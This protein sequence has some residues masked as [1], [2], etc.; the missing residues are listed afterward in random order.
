MEM[1]VQV[2]LTPAL[3]YGIGINFAEVIV[4]FI[5]C[6]LFLANAWKG[7]IGK[8]VQGK[9]SV[10]AGLGLLAG[11]FS[12]VLF[13]AYDYVSQDMTWFLMAGVVQMAA[14]LVIFLAFYLALKPAFQERGRF[15]VIPVILFIGTFYGSYALIAGLGQNLTV[16]LAGNTMVILC[17]CLICVYFIRAIRKKGA[18][19]TRQILVLGAGWVTAVLGGLMTS[20]NFVAQYPGLELVVKGIGHTLAVGGYI[21]WI[22]GFW[23][24]PVL[25]E[26]E[27]RGQLKHLYLIMKSGICI[28]DQ[29]YA[30]DGT[31]DSNL[32]AGGIT[33]ITALIQEMTSSK[34]KLEVIHQEGVN[35]LLHPGT[36]TTGVLVAGADLQILHRK[37]SAF[38]TEGES[39]FQ[40]E[41]PSWQ[42]KLEV[43]APLRVLA[44]RHF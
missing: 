14:L 19:V 43:F 38:V 5:G 15:L 35:I 24:L 28:Y 36:Y 4:A 29:S 13:I 9:L 3:V 16:L 20:T 37:L 1:L 21:A 44:E 39:L 12:R 27:W 23:T 31:V 18:D 25:K 32:V 2:N 10:V 41:L 33:G 34:G 6:G 11:G 30:G 26:L 22:A 7:E 42:G 17:M 40:Y 8:G